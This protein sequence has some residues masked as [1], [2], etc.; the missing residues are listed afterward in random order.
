[1]KRKRFSPRQVVRMFRQAE[2][3]L[4]SGKRAPQGCKQLRIAEHVCCSGKNQY[5]EMKTREAKQLKELGKDNTG[6][7]GSSRIAN[8]AIGGQ[9]F[10]QSPDAQKRA[11][12][13]CLPRFY[14]RCPNLRGLRHVEF[15]VTHGVVLQD[16]QKPETEYQPDDGDAQ[17]D[18]Q[19]NQAYVRT[20]V[21]AG[22]MPTALGACHLHRYLQSNTALATLDASS[23]CIGAEIAARSAVRAGLANRFWGAQAGVAFGAAHERSHPFRGHLHGVQA[24]SAL[25]L[26]ERA[27][28]LRPS[29]HRRRQLSNGYDRPRRLGL[30]VVVPVLWHRA[31]TRLRACSNSMTSP[32]RRHGVS[33]RLTSHFH[34]GGRAQRLNYASATDLVQFRR[35]PMPR[36]AAR[37]APQAKSVRP[38]FSMLIR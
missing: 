37:G 31:S 15:G 11:L 8:G 24:A 19:R 10:L 13:F 29:A 6:K 32:W 23:G 30:V 12:P 22:A 14:G 33:T 18:D 21:A 28:R 5:G 20:S 36:R 34:I 16:C 26:G 25:Q 27:I 7:L 35:Q 2:M 9:Q 38:A 17:R 3:L 4:A 1:M